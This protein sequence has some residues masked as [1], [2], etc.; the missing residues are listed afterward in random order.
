MHFLYKTQDFFKKGNNELTARQ[1]WVLIIMP[2]CFLKEKRHIKNVGFM[3]LRRCALYKFNALIYKF[4]A[5]HSSS[6]HKHIYTHEKKKEENH[7]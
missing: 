5:M 7:I 6:P 3:D 2:I 1:I 4:C